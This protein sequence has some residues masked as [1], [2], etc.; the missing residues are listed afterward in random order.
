[1]CIRDRLQPG[2]VAVVDLNDLYLAHF[3]LTLYDALQ[4]R[5]RGPTRRVLEIGAGYGGTTAKLALLLPSTRF[6]II[7]LPPANLLQ[8][9]YLSELFPGEVTVLPHTA[10]SEGATTSTRFT[11]CSQTI[12]TTSAIRFDGIINTRSF[13]EMESS[14]ISRYFDLIHLTLNPGG[15]LM[16]VNRFTK[17][18]NRFRDYPYD[19]RWSVIDSRPSL[20]QE[21]KIWSLVT[22]RL[23]RDNHVFGFWKLKYWV[24]TRRFM[25]AFFNLSARRRM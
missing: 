9:Y 1:M 13:A 11:I 4:Q 7:D 17:L 10:T 24:F 16:N 8:A 23:D 22:Q 12:E 19:S 6:T 21:S 18:G 15:I 2:D 20:G 14:E 5:P 3:A 25:R